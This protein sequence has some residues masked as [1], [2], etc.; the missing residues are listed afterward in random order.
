MDATRDH[1]E[2]NELDTER[3]MLPVFSR[4]RN[5]KMGKKNPKTKNNLCVSA[6]LQI[7]SHQNFFHSFAKQV[8]QN[9]ML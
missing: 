9:I 7:G 8:I 6:L 4:K 2:L 5:F 1:V 3:G